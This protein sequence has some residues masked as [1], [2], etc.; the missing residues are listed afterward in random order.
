[1]KIEYKNI[2]AK[3]NDSKTFNRHYAKQVLDYRNIQVYDIGHGDQFDYVVN[4]A[5]FSQR[6][7][8]SK[9]FA[10][11]LI[12]CMIDSTK[13]ENAT[14]DTWTRECYKKAEKAV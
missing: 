1:M 6:A 13:H 7:G 12:D 14:V 2:W 3:I 5:C 4:G 11:N 9:E 8:F 10:T